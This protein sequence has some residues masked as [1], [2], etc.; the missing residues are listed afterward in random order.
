M[1][2]F[3]LNSIS[4]RFFFSA[5]FA[6]IYK[7]TFFQLFNWAEICSIKSIVKVNFVYWG[8]HEHVSVPALKLK[9]KCFKPFGKQIW[10]VLLREFYPHSDIIAG[11]INFSHF[12]LTMNMTGNRVPA[13]FITHFKRPLQVHRIPLA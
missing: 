12:A 3:F 9:K 8:S 13:N 10:R 1:S 4:E 6:K 2:S 11:R 7:C 5:K